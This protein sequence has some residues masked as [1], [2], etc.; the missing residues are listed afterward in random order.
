MWVHSRKPISFYRILEANTPEPRL[1][2]FARRKREGWDSWGNEIESDIELEQ[3][4]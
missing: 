4:K 1:E 3:L 2:L